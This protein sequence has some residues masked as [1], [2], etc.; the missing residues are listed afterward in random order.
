MTVKIDQ[1]QEL[2]KV[3]PFIRQCRRVCPVAE[4]AFR[5]FW[6]HRRYRGPAAGVTWVTME[7]VG[8]RI[9]RK[10]G[11]VNEHVRLMEGARLLT[12]L[13]AG[14]ENRPNIYLMPGHARPTDD[15]LAVEL[16][17]AWGVDPLDAPGVLAAAL[18][19]T[20]HRR[21]RRRLHPSERMLRTGPARIEHRRHKVE[22]AGD[23]PPVTPRKSAQGRPPKSACNPVSPGTSSTRATSAPPRWVVS[24]ATAPPPW[25]DAERAAWRKRTATPSITRRGMFGALDLAAHPRRTW[26]RATAMVALHESL[27]ASEF[28]RPYG[29]A[30]NE[31][32]G[33]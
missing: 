27:A 6:K 26:D 33:S 10:A 5:V 28:G 2:V 13:V 20:A 1:G 24:T 25:T 15:A 29:P 3:D 22:L 30:P 4:R 23:N 32:G 18:A 17:I 31:R 8:S 16:A 11:T 7:G 14:G 21:H 12:L 19:T 9:G